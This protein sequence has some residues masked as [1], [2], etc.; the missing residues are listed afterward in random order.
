MKKTLNAALA[1]L[2]IAGLPA[3]A[4]D[5]VWNPEIAAGN[6]NDAANWLV[7]GAA[8]GSYPSTADDTAA[9]SGGSAVVTVT[10]NVTVGSMTVDTSNSASWR[11]EGSGDYYI[12]CK[13]TIVGDATG[14]IV[15]KRITPGAT[16]TKRMGGLTIESAPRQL[17][18]DRQCGWQPS[19][20]NLPDTRITLLRHGSLKGGWSASVFG[21]LA[22]FGENYAYSDAVMEF[23][24]LIDMGG[25]ACVEVKSGK[26]KFRNPSS[27]KLI[28]GT[29]T[30][31]DA[32][33][34][35]PVAPQFALAATSTDCASI[36]L[37]IGMPIG[38]CTIDADG[39]VQEI[40]V[41][42]MKQGFD[43]AGELDNVYISSATTLTEDLTI[44]AL[45]FGANIDLGGH[46]LTIK[47]GVLRPSAKNQ[48]YGISNGTIVTCEPMLLADG[49]NNV[50]ERMSCEFATAGND[51]PAKAM[52]NC[53]SVGGSCPQQSTFANFTG[54][55]CKENSNAHLYVKGLA[56][57]QV[58]REI[59]DGFVM[60]FDNHNMYVHGVGL[61][62][63]GSISA[64]GK[65]NPRIYLGSLPEGESEANYVFSIGNGGFVAPGSMAEDGFRRG[66]IGVC[67]R[68]GNLNGFENVKFLSGSTLKTVLRPDGTATLFDCSSYGSYGSHYSTVTL[69]GDLELAEAAR[70][71]GEMTWTVLKSGKL[72]N[73]EF[74]SVT[75][76]YTVAYN[77][78]LGTDSY[79]TTIYGVTV[80]KDPQPVADNSIVFSLSDP[81]YSAV[82][83][84]LTLS[85]SASKIGDE[86]NF[87]KATFEWG[88]TDALGETETLTTAFGADE[89][90]SK[91]LAG[92]KA[93]DKIYYRVTLTSDVA[94]TE[95][96]A[97]QVYKVPVTVTFTDP[98]FDRSA[99]TITVSAAVDSAV[100]GTMVWGTSADAL[101]QSVELG[102]GSS[103]NALSHTFTEVDPAETVYYRIRVVD[104]EGDTVETEIASVTMPAGGAISAVAAVA[105]NTQITISVH[106]DDLGYGA[107]TLRYLVGTA[108]GNLNV[109]GSET[110]Q[111]SGDYRFDW[112]IGE[113]GTF[114]YAVEIVNEYTG[115]TWTTRLLGESSIDVADNASYYWVGGEGN[116]SDAANWRSD[117]AGAIGLPNVKSEVFIKPDVDSVLQLTGTTT[118]DKL[119]LSTANAA[120]TI[121]G[122]ALVANSVDMVN[123]QAAHQL[124]LDAC[125]LGSRS[126]SAQLKM[127][128]QVDLL[129]KLKLVNE[130]GI[131]LGS[132]LNGTEVTLYG[133]DWLHSGS[134]ISQICGVLR[135]GRGFSK[136]T[137]NWNFSG[138]A[139]LGHVGVV[140]VE[141]GKVSF[142]DCSGIETIGGIAPG[143]ALC[144]A[145]GWANNRFGWGVCKIDANGTVRSVPIEELHAG[146]TGATENDNV[147]LSESVTLESDMTVNAILLGN[148]VTLDLN[149]H[150]LTVKSGVIRPYGQNRCFVKNG[151][152]AVERSMMTFDTYN[153]AALRFSAD[154]AYVGEGK[155]EIAFNSI[156]GSRPAP[157][158]F[159]GFNG[160]V[161]AYT[162]WDHPGDVALADAVLELWQKGVI[163]A[164]AHNQ[165]LVYGGAAGEFTFNGTKF[166]EVHWLGS[167]NGVDN[168][169]ERKHRVVLADGGVLAPGAWCENGYR[170]GCIKF[171]PSTSD[172]YGI[173]YFEMLGGTLSV[174][175]HFDGEATWLDLRG[176][177]SWPDKKGIQVT[178]G[179]DLEIVA[180]GKAPT[181][182]TWTILRTQCATTGAFANA[183]ENGKGIEGYRVYYNVEQPDGTYA[184][185][186]TRTLTALF[187][188]LR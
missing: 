122:A 26:M 57:T 63:N 22:V 61:G 131:Y 47:S 161:F 101:E 172:L 5:F 102:S 164:A 141:D 83:G 152:V 144:T 146:L 12:S 3:L 181:G 166:N 114:F 94:T 66:R 169:R 167:T 60:N 124:T 183:G 77:V 188:L 150:V 71:P 110:I 68:T 92:V 100:T 76:G 4:T 113:E 149:G 54:T 14:K 162:K 99:K 7:D 151:T 17:V 108:A 65:F 15:F 55:I 171:N 138:Y 10:S 79:G 123:A 8:T 174:T 140:G 24:S 180:A 127:V 35:I 51:D 67:Y 88:A 87:V 86:A 53:V 62:G 33:P 121:K 75:P 135:A 178:L 58:C 126:N 38:A 28:G 31:A 6:W 74:E 72:I 156:G 106:V 13:P 163:S 170:R 165:T 128:E 177:T 142:A 187:F 107:V 25:V 29:Q 43:G 34:Q 21:D 104:S 137:G 136:L 2:A 96:S 9:F 49:G 109:I 118:I 32:G 179:G 50:D 95:K 44:N 1:A 182:T 185:E 56:A 37:N 115:D 143:F 64:T 11:F 45:V 40:P 159:V 89:A 84:T 111:S 36:G 48:Y 91:T 41:A 148:E 175:L 129:S 93:M 132:S 186:V 78:D 52:L 133:E 160:S 90:F 184:C 97:I 98:V 20:V 158:Q 112:T 173:S 153:N 18:F 27:V 157:A 134:G 145:N 19:G 82:D 23:G 168:L 105:D 46:T 116:W 155:G 39:I 147:Y 120:V 70:C 103:E 69:A 85:G 42:T 119:H 125:V 16:N 59:S 80:T 73:G 154:I 176:A 117:D 139:D 130:S 30:L 81:V